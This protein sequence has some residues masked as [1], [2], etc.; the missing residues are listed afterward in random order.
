MTTV[1]EANARGPLVN[2]ASW[3]TLVSAILAAGV[4]LYTKMSI[5]KKVQLD[6]ALLLVAV[7]SNSSLTS[8]YLIPLTLTEP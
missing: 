8:H 7:V 2:I 4:K 1:S 5:T 3:I 6:D